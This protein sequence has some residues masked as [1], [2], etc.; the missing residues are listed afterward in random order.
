MSVWLGRFSLWCPLGRWVVGRE[1]RDLL[2]GGGTSPPSSDSPLEAR[3]MRVP[4]RFCHTTMGATNG[5]HFWLPVIVGRIVSR[6]PAKRSRPRRCHLVYVSLRAPADTSLSAWLDPSL[7]HA[8][9]S[10][11]Q[12]SRVGSPSSAS[13]CATL[14]LSRCEPASKRV[15]ST[16]A[17][18]HRAAPNTLFCPIGLTSF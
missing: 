3:L 17:S 9:K 15:Y 4:P 12:C 11:Q 2:R 14:T 8:I 16:R 1:L 5:R 18:L 6:T 10:D 7:R 13:S